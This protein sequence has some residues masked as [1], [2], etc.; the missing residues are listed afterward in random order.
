MVSQESGIEIVNQPRD[1]DWKQ[2]RG[3]EIMADALAAYP[4]ID[5]V[6]AHNDPMA[7]GAYLA[8]KE[9]GREKDIIF[10]GVDGIPAEGVKWVNE[11]I[12]TATFLYKPPGGE[13]IRQALRFLSG[14][15]IPKQLTLP[16]LTIDRSNASEILRANGLL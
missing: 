9:A 6:Y 7:Y 1:G 15:V 13:A 14:E 5:L 2:D 10:L 11:G 4:R 12:L 16:T 8:A 3:Y